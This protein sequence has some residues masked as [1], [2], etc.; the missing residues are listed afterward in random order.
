MLS[1]EHEVVLGGRAVD[2][3]EV[4]GAT[5]VITRCGDWG[6]AVWLWLPQE[7]MSLKI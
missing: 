3:L 4:D 2:V 5:V 7:R 6:Q 1:I